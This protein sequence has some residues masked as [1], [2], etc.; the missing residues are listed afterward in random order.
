MKSLKFFAG[1][2]I[3]GCCVK[4]GDSPGLSL[5]QPVEPGVLHAP[6]GL[7]VDG[8]RRVRRVVGGFWICCG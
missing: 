1:G 7:A 4:G 6:Q 2:Y 8:L 5:R 3:H